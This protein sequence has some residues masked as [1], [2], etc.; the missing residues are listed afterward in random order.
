MSDMSGH[1]N[2]KAGLWQGYSGTGCLPRL[3]P[4]CHSFM[5]I[6]RGLFSASPLRASSR[7]LQ[8]Q[9]HMEAAE[10]ETLPPCSF[11]GLSGM[12]FLPHIL[13]LHD[14]SRVVPLL[15][16][17]LAPNA[18]SASATSLLLCS[19]SCE[20]ITSAPRCPAPKIGKWRV[21]QRLRH[22]VTTLHSHTCMMMPVCLL[23]LHS[24]C[25]PLL[26]PCHL[27]LPLLRFCRFFA[28]FFGAFRRRMAWPIVMYVWYSHSYLIRSRPNRILRAYRLAGGGGGPLLGGGIVGSPTPRKTHVPF[29]EHLLG[30]FHTHNLPCACL[31]I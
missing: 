30:T 20:G 6:R 9:C 17:P 1:D 19:R 5:I 7:L 3:H 21:I 12:L 16:H 26:T 27:S 2:R 10:V 15:H 28:A 8:L 22:S 4:P 24:L 31:L 25:C 23:C 14:N 18:P 13:V 11:M 29:Q